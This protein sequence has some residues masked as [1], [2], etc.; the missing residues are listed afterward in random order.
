MKTVYCLCG[1]GSDERIFSKLNWDGVDVH[2]LPWIMP[3]AGESLSAYAVRMSESIED[4]NAT[5][6]GV[7]FGGMMSIEIAKVRKIYK[8]VLIS[9]VSNRLQLPGWMR[10][11]GKMNADSL[12]PRKSLFSFRPTK[13][14]EP[15]ENYFLGASTEEEKKLVHEYRANVDPVYLKWSIHQ[16]LRW[17]NEWQPPAL[18]HIHGDKDRIFPYSLVTPTHTIPS[19]GHFLVYQEAERV[20]A[21]LREIL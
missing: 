15:L 16:V 21:I 11:F 3:S 9:S 20:S 19:A 12:L 2:Y 4:E 17:N 1:L 5:L 13:I 7:S 8:V 18:Y 6:I 14:F 10:L